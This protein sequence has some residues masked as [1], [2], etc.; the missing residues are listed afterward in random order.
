MEQIAIGKLA[1]FSSLEELA[2]IR[3]SSE[4]RQFVGPI[5]SL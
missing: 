2:L 1:A 5:I 3:A 4:H